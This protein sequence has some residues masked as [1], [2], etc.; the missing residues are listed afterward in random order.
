MSIH[1]RRGFLTP[2]VLILRHQH[3]LSYQEHSKTSNANPVNLLI[4]NILVQTRQNKKYVSK[5]LFCKQI[6]LLPTVNTSFSCYHII[7]MKLKNMYKILFCK[8]VN[9]GY[10]K[11]RI[12]VQNKKKNM[13]L[14]YYSVN[15]FFCCQPFTP[16]F[17]VII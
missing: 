11:L 13:Y 6:F 5:I 16:F 14:K 2:I 3:S 15:R 7:I 8:Q 12:L 1:C 9:P 4:L 17:H 10:Q